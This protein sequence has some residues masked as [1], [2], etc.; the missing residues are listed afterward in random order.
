[1]NLNNELEFISAPS[2]A[3]LFETTKEQRASFVER[4]LDS[5]LTGNADPLKLHLQIKSMEE[6]VKSILDNKE[7]KDAILGD[8]SRHGKKFTHMNADWDIREMGVSY[9]YDNCGDPVLQSL[10]DSHA[11][12]TAKLKERQ[13]F[14]QTIPQEGATIVNEDT[15]EVFKITPPVKKSTTTVTVKLK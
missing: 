15:G 3:A 9:D 14:L 5:L 8:A 1:M 13:K 4:I 2:I 12:I 7:Y 11:E 6:I 10:M